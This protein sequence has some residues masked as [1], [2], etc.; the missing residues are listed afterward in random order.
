MAIVDYPR[1][2][3]G[4][5]LAARLRRASAAIDADAAR[6][7]A[8]LGVTFEQ[9]WFGVLDALSQEQTL[10]V[11]E[12]A[13][14]L[15]ISHAAV[16]QTRQSLEQGGL[17]VSVSDPL[18][19]RRRKLALSAEG[20]RLVERLRPFWTALAE[21]AEELDRESGGITRRLDQLEEALARRSLFDR[22]MTRV[23]ET[24]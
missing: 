18:D 10:T 8:A 2:A 15:G 7:Y 9:R 5:A 11:N 1:S 21:V 16:S 22:I 12:L 24:S 3:R 14:F 23:D 20:L 19:A 6:V 13:A 17:I 4:G